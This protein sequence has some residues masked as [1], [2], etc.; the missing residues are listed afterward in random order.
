VAYACRRAGLSPKGI[1]NS[2][3]AAKYGGYHVFVELALK[4]LALCWLRPALRPKGR[5]AYACLP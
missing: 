4:A 1:R 5:V 3:R 2:L